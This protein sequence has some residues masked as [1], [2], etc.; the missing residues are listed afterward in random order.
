M[1]ED[2]INPSAPKI[3]TATD[4]QNQP[5]N[6]PA[7]IISKQTINNKAI[8]TQITPGWLRL[9]FAAS[10]FDNT[11]IGIPL[12]LIYSILIL[13]GVNLIKISVLTSLS[14]LLVYSLFTLIYFIYFDVNKGFTP[15]KK[16]YGLKVIDNTTNTNLTYL[17]AFKREFINRFLIVIP[18]IGALYTLIN[19]FIMLSSDE[20][21][22]VH[23]KFSGSKVII[24]NKSWPIWKQFILFIR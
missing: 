24:V 10:F 21:K 18:L 3:P 2:N 14:V 22:G 9:R 5:T 16:I 19:F 15:G 7:T 12:Y 8:E 6:S 13:T 4:V 1:E 17:N 23:D 20:R 11:I